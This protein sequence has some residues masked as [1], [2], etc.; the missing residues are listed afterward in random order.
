MMS[1]IVA[2]NDSKWPTAAVAAG[3]LEAAELT[4]PDQP[5][6]RWDCALSGHS[7]NIGCRLRH[8]HMYHQR[9]F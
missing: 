4:L 5:S 9:G 1:P 6:E 8:W 3:R 2:R 7:R